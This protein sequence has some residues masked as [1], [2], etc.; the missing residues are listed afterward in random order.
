MDME[1]RLA[2]PQ[3]RNEVES[4]WAALNR[5]KIRFFNGT[6]LNFIRRKMY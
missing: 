2:G 1:F 4:L 5:G 6:F 3:D